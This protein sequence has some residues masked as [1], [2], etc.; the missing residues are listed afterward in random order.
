MLACPSGRQTGHNVVSPQVH[1]TFR[2]RGRVLQNTNSWQIWGPFVFEGI[3][4]LPR[5]LSFLSSPC[6]CASVVNNSVW[7]RLMKKRPNFLIIMTEQH[8]GDCLGIDGHPCLLTPNMDAIGWKGVRFSKAYT[9]CATCI[10]ARRSFLSGQYPSTHGMVGYKEEVEWDA[11]TTL[12]G[13]MSSAGYQA[14]WVGRGIHQYPRRKRFGFDHMVTTEDYWEWLAQN[15]PPGSGGY[16]GTG[17]MHNDWTARPWHMPEGLHHTNW[18]VNQTLEFLEKRDP[19]CPFFLVVSFQAA[20]P[21]LIPPACYME[22][23][24]RMDL[25]APFI[26]DWETRPE[27]S[28]RAGGSGAIDVNLTGEALRSCRAGYYGLINHVDDQIWRLFN[29]VNGIDRMTDRNTVVMLT[30][31]HG[32]ML[33]D[34]YRFHKMLP[35]ESSSRIPLLIRGL[36][37]L[38]IKKGSVCDRPV[39]LEDIMPTVLDIAGVEIPDT[40][41]GHSLLPL[42]RGEDAPA[43]EY[44]HLE[45]APAH[46]SL[47]DGKEKYIWFV[48]EGREQFFDLTEDPNECHDLIND[49]QAKDRVSLWRSRLVEELKDRPEGFSDG[50]KLI[51]GRPYSAVLEKSIQ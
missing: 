24:L 32:E 47:T 11:P 20:H 35:Y 19:S 18:T 23:Y 33:G 30:S 29:N 5:L 13:A 6:L 40:V 37:H 7:R 17:V 28:W 46:H 51:P 10:A 44:L 15:E 9:T 39:C 49:A 42:M 43:H 2:V 50:K 34:H 4:D 16:Y 41:D 45:H 25:P 14:V 31:D 21:P 27:E 1:R 26:G 12:P 38:G 36:D 8:R 48:R 22:R 3:A